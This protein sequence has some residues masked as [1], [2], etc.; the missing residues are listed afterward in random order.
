M[1]YIGVDFHLVPAKDIDEMWHQHILHTLKYAQDC[2][3]VFGRFVHHSPG[4]DDSAEM[5]D[6]VR[7]NFR[8]TEALYKELFGEDYVGGWLS[9]FL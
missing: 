9:Y 7:A 3:R 2:E 1:R 5:V 4:I 6:H 8:K